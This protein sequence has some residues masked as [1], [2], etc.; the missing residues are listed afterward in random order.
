MHVKDLPLHLKCM[1][2]LLLW[3]GIMILGFDYEI[4]T[5]SSAAV[6]KIKKLNTITFK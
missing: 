4:K 3:S 5:S 6:I 2:L 1:K